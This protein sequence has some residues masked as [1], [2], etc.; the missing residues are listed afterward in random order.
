MPNSELRAIIVPTN[1]AG[2]C[3]LPGCRQKTQQSAGEG[4]SVRY[5][6]HHVEFHRRHGSHWHRSIAAKDLAPARRA[7]KQWLKANRDDR[8]VVT[9]LASVDALLKEAGRYLNAYQ[10]RGKSPEERA[11]F[12]LARLRNAEIAPATILE[13]AIAVSAHCEARGIDERQREFRKVQMAKSVHRLASGTHRTT[14]GFM[15]P[16]KYP[17][18]EGQVLRHLGSWMDEIVEYALGGRSVW[19]QQPCE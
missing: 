8:R 17:R 6:K 10:I 12:A 2:K 5:C 18:S 15:I 14:S 19:R 16:T 4:Y 11:R 3:T 1:R 7:T 9:A 13:R